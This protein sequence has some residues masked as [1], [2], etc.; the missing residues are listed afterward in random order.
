MILF[1][2]CHSGP[3]ALPPALPHPLLLALP[4]VWTG[5]EENP[6]IMGDQGSPKV[7]EARAH[8]WV[9]WL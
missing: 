7:I 9:S 1:T 4:G 3:T 5:R 6:D 2:G 8:G